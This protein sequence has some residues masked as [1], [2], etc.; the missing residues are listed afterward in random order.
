VGSSGFNGQHRD[1]IQ[2]AGAQSLDDTAQ[3]PAA[4]NRKD[5]YIR[6]EASLEGLVDDGA[7]PLPKERIVKWVDIRAA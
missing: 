7:V 6:N 4:S 5:H 3:K 1:L 2:S